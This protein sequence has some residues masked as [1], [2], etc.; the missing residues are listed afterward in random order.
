MYY[1]ALGYVTAYFTVT[2]LGS[3][4]PTILQIL[5]AALVPFFIKI[6]DVVGRVESVSIAILFYLVGLTIQG[7]AGS[8]VQVAVGQIFY[9]MGSTGVLVLT[10]VVIAGEELFS[11]RQSV[12]MLQFIIFQPHADQVLL[13]LSRSCMTILYTY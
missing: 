12:A 1:G 2:S 10:Q 7:A 6:S 9:G 3:I 8:F 13:S 11:P 4:L 5:R